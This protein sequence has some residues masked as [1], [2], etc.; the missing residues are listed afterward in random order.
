MDCSWIYKRNTY[1]GDNGTRYA[2]KHFY[3]TTRS[4][5]INRQR[6][7]IDFIEG[8]VAKWDFSGETAQIVGEEVKLLTTVSRETKERL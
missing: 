1:H 6:E 3:K 4:V 2:T 5:Y 8:L 7:E